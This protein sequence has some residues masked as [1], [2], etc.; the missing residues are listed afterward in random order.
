MAVAKVQEKAKGRWITEGL[1]V[2]KRKGVLAVAETVAEEAKMEQ[3]V[4]MLVKQK[5]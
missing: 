2:V 5:G 3:A 4:G 1:A